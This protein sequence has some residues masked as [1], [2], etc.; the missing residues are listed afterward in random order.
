MAVLLLDELRIY[1]IYFEFL[2][3]EM[4][5]TRGISILYPPQYIYPQRNPDFVSFLWFTFLLA[6][7]PKKR[8]IVATNVVVW[9]SSPRK[10][11]LLQ[12]P[13]GQPDLCSIEVP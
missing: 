12:I 8:K 13:A 2:T 9:R 1:P 5:P 4:P 6:H 7:I 10:V 11:V 3:L